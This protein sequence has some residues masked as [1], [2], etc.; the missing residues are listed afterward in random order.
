MSSKDLRDM[1]ASMT[2]RA[3]M[4][5]LGVGRF[6]GLFVFALCDDSTAVEDAVAVEELIATAVCGAIDA[7]LL[8]WRERN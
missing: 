7:Y 6:E 1:V 2:A 4:E 5:R 8:M 3:V